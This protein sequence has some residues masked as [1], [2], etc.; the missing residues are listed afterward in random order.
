M[1]KKLQLDL[2]TYRKRFHFFNLCF[3]SRGYGKI[4]RGVGVGEPTTG[5]KEAAHGHR[6]YPKQR[7]RRKGTKKLKTCRVKSRAKHEVVD[8]IVGSTTIAAGRQRR[9]P[10]PVKIRAKNRGVAVAAELRER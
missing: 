1:E 3:G 8:V 9:L 5:Q 7:Y 4:G 10:D 6:I 2:S